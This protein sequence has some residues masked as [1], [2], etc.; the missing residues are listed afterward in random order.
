MYVHLKPFLCVNPFYLIY[1]LARDSLIA[2]FFLLMFEYESKKHYIRFRLQ[3]LY[4]I[5]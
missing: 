4:R 5:R 2:Q 1:V 3:G